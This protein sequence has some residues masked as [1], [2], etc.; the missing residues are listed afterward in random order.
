MCKCV[1]RR[2]TSYYLCGEYTLNSHR[3]AFIPLIRKAYELYFGCKIGHPEKPGHHTFAAVPVQLISK[4]GWMDQDHRW[5]LLFH[6]FSVNEKI[7]KLTSIF[8]W[9]ICLGSM[10]KTKKAIQYPD[11]SSAM[12]PMLYDDSFPV[13]TL[14]TVWALDDNADHT[15]G[16]SRHYLDVECD[17][18]TD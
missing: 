8:V 3:K 16:T 7:T 1:H 11:L 15:V 9:Q 12:Q 14:S 18:K 17:K 6:L 13:P 5:H 4:L 10:L 2:D